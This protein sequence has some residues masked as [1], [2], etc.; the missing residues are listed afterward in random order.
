MDVPVIRA[1]PKA[2]T[3]NPEDLPSQPQDPGV[4]IRQSRAGKTNSIRLSLVYSM[5]QG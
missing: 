3:R 4:K 5:S 1:V 2:E